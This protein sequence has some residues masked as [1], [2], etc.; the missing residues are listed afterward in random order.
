[1]SPPF[2]HLPHHLHLHSLIGILSILLLHHHSRRPHPLHQCTQI[3]PTISISVDLKKP[4]SVLGNWQYNL[5]DKGKLEQQIEMLE[6]KEEKS[7]KALDKCLGNLNMVTIGDSKCNN[8]Q[9]EGFME[10]LMKC[11]MT[12]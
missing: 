1:M 8:L 3:L 9:Q 6:R 10:G 11:L 4:I 12:L 7:L 5:G 2:P